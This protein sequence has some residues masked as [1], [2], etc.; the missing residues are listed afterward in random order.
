VAGAVRQAVASHNDW[1][2]HF[3]DI[4]ATAW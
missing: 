4:A 3:D 2:G 1:A